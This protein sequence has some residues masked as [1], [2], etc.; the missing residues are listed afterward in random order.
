MFKPWLNLVVVII[1][2]LLL[3]Q[4][5]LARAEQKVP[6]PLYPIQT[7]LEDDKRE[8]V[9]PSVAGNFVVYSQRVNNEYSV[10]RTSVGNIS[11]EGKLIAA[12]QPKEAIRYGVA[13]KDGAIGYVSNR[14]GPI[15]AWMNQGQGDGH[16]AIAN[17][18]TFTGALMPANLKASANGKIWAFDT[19]LEKTRRARVLDDYSDGFKQEEFTGQSW[20][21][22]HS[23][24]WRYKQGY[25]PTQT[26][27]RNKFQ[28]PALFLFDR[29]SSQLTMFHNAFNGALSPDGKRVV[30][31]RDLGGNYDLWMQ[32]VDGSGL[33][34]ITT[35]TFGDFEPAFSP[36]GNRI[37]FISNRDSE[38][39]VRVTSIYVMDLKSGK[40]KRVTNALR[41]TD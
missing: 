9:Y 8:T 32:N 7:V 15:G 3:S 22:Y 11:A 16:V 25:Y 38:G 18:G 19:S 39:D 21:L 5:A 20:R 6:E 28:A 14:M 26:G 30:F 1:A 37:A 35:N 41:A 29:D 33:A 34:Q 27:T 17:M 10:V 23:D 36:D 31:V 12:S 40:I 2:V 4:N 24:A 13:I